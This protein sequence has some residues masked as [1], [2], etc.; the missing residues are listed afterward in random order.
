[1]AFGPLR[2]IIRTRPLVEVVNFVVFY[3]RRYK[4]IIA[5]DP[6]RF[7][8]ALP[9]GTKIINSD[10]IL[11]SDLLA[12]ETKEQ[13]A[14][15]QPIELLQPQDPRCMVKHICQMFDE[16]KTDVRDLFE[17]GYEGFQTYLR[18]VVRVC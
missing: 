4:R 1:L 7:F 13:F 12:L 3:A 16:L 5:A 6:D 9:V 18:D 10:A 2:S 14:R 8:D 15:I 11:T 17:T